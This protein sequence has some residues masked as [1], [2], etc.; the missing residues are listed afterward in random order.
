MP[1]KLLLR[2]LSSIVM[3]TM[4]TFGCSLPT[5]TTSSPP[6]TTKALTQTTPTM[7]TTTTKISTIVPTT[8][9]YTPASASIITVNTNPKQKAVLLYNNLPN[10]YKYTCV[11]RQRDANGNFLSDYNL[12]SD[13]I[14]PKSHAIV[15]LPNNITNEFTV[16]NLHSVSI[17]IKDQPK[18]AKLSISNL[19]VETITNTSV[20]KTY[21]SLSFILI[22]IG[23]DTGSGIGGNS[24]KPVSITMQILSHTPDGSLTLVCESSLIS[25]SKLPPLGE[26]VTLNASLLGNIVIIDAAK[27]II[28]GEINIIAPDK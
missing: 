10:F 21:Q 13:F 14:A 26:H 7:P 20:G 4:F 2:V 18:F 6:T 25:I 27:G 19:Q 16:E 22:N 5:S 8:T 24:I 1:K 23:E 28:D 17:P 12:T 15:F 3:L 9:T 11:I